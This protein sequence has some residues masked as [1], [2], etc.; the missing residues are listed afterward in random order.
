M[1]N[2][3]II[4]S[5]DSTGAVAAVKRLSSELSG[6]QSISAKALAFGGIVSVGAAVAALTSITKAAIDQ[7]DALNKLSQSTGIAAEDLSKLQYAA[8]LSGVSAEALKKGLVA[9][10]VDMAAAATGAGPAAE[11]YAKFGV[12]VRNA[13]GTIKSSLDV[14]G[15]LADRFQQMP[16]GVEKTDL[17]VDIFGKRLGADMIPLLNLGAAGLKAMG[18]E[19]QALGLVMSG[20]L[21]KK[22]EE[23]NDN[24][25]RLS[26]LSSTAGINI[27]QA[28][29][30][31]I[32][33]LLTAFLDSRN[34]GLGFAQS[35]GNVLDS[36]VGLAGPLSVAEKGIERVTKK[37]EE[38]KKKQ[39]EGGLSLA[40]FGNVDKQIAE[41]EQL[42]K[43]YQAQQARQTGDGIQSAEQLAAKRLVIEAQMQTKMAELAKLRGIAEGKVSADILQTDDK[44]IAAQIANAQKLRD[45]LSAAWKQ[46]ITDAEAAG[47]AAEA[48]FE[49]AADIRANAEDKA[50]SKER[51]IDPGAY[52]SPFRSAS[53]DNA[54]KS[55]SIE[56]DYRNAAN[57]A[58]ENATLAKFAAQNGRAENAAR[59]A[60]QAAKDAERA[61]ALADQITDPQA[62][63]NA[64]REAAQL[65]AGLQEAQAQAEQKKQKDLE[66]RATKQ[67]ELVAGLDQQITDLQ[68]KAA[69]IQ[70]SA[71]IAAAQGALATL[72]TQL[73]ALQDKTITVTVVTKNEGGATGDFSTGAEGSFAR[74]G[75]T[76]PGGKWQPAGIVHAGEFVHRQEVVRQPGALAFLS[77]FN[78]EGMAALRRNGYAA[79]GLV[80]NLAMPSLNRATPAAASAN[81]TFN[82]PG[83]GSFQATL[84]PDVMSE[85]KEAFSRE[86]LKKGGRR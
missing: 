21:A 55:G 23:F 49:K 43:Y 45:A 77:R 22:S 46:S 50:R 60:K 54:S 6:L 29:I 26:K 66:E 78:R 16:D 1:A 62:S 40:I 52:D 73:A 70:V 85:L 11:K 8:D 10:S 35:V 79:G 38:L 14:L 80:S 9:L 47:K 33:N 63:A 15:Q 44:R 83:M 34:A 3:K 59:L 25:A 69:S 65:S 4:I 31:S 67:N 37:I 82:F 61:V 30:P 19:A 13:D 39:A 72:Q 18:D 68:A 7:G 56:Q 53:G 20:D 64:I 71:D 75:Y 12:S 74:G 24:L 84:A 5:G 28:L 2:P 32:N 81:A 58:D 57:A 17:A 51:S 42:L 48:A 41:Q 76:G 86:A 36:A 27:A